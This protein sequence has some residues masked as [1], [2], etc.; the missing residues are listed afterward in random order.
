[1]A[2]KDTSLRCV[3]KQGNKGVEGKTKEK[4]KEITKRKQL[5]VSVSEYEDKIKR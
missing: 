4:P 5:S 1:M 2:S 3:L